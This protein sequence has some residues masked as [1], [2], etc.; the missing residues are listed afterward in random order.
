MGAR[1]FGCRAGWRAKLALSALLSL[2]A[3]LPGT[4]SAQDELRIAAV[5]NEEVISAR[6]LDNRLKVVIVTSGLSDTREERQRLSAQVLRNLIDE[7]LQMQEAKRLNVGVTEQE[8]AESVERIEKGNNIP[9]GTFESVIA[10]SGIDKDSVFAQL[11]ATIA[12]N[13][14][15]RQQLSPSVQVVDEEVNEILGNIER[16]Q[17]LPQYRISEI[18]LPVDDPSREEDVKQNA[19]KLA[20]QVRGGANFAAVAWQFSAAASAG[21]GGEVGWILE[22]QLDPAIARVIHELKSGDISSP[23]RTVSGYQ[24][25]QLAEERTTTASQPEDAVVQLKQVM[26]A[27]DAKS[28]PE[29][30][31]AKSKE[32][33]SIAGQAKSC[34]DM[35]HLAELAKS[36]APSSLGRFRLGEINS[37]LRAV[38][39]ELKPGE[40]SRA[41]LVPNGVAVLM[42]CERSEPTSNAPSRQEV[43]DQIFRGKISV[44]MRRY[45]R[46]LR[47]GAFLEVRS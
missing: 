13:K 1:A 6:D 10:G 26:L 38:V 21:S 14:V 25:I 36:P 46:D 8:L 34:D 24:I 9:A 30:V 35:D 15:V 28:G 2:A 5:V 39:A 40:P 47:R 44:I 17:N 31:E 32:V 37:A 45:M 12:W 4:G 23:I 7:R 27:L 42:V 18:L 20:E 33:E 41:V 16:T 19:S 29:V 22:D 3:F 11:R 43:R